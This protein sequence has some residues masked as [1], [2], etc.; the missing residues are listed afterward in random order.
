MEVPT[1]GGRS[2]GRV[3]FWLPLGFAIVCG[4]VLAMILVLLRTE[5]IRSGERLTQ[6][7]AQLTEDQTTRTIQAVDQTLQLARLRLAGLHGTVTPA[8]A[9]NLRL[10]LAA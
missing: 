1:R 10:A 4:S 6:V 5:A 8:D 3:V 9:Q 2:T 7:F